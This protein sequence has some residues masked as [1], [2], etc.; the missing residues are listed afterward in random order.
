VSSAIALSV[1]LSFAALD[2][3]IGVAV[4]NL[5]AKTLTLATIYYEPGL[6]NREIS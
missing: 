3:H 4:K 2:T 1:A 6:T 5:N